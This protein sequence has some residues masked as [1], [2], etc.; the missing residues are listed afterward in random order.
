MADRI[1]IKML[2]AQVRTLNERLGRPTEPWSATGPMMKGSGNHYRANIG[3]IHLSQAYGGVQ[4]V[5]MV[6]DGGAVRSLTD[7]HGPKREAWEVLRG[8]HAVLD[9]AERQA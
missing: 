9:S 8:M 5:E 6:N 7:Y 1:T 2:E 4:V 3:N